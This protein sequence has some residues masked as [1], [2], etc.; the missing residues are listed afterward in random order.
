MSLCWA[1]SLPAVT[2]S[3]Q[4]W[5]KPFSAYLFSILSLYSHCAHI[6]TLHAAYLVNLLPPGQS[7]YNSSCQQYNGVYYLMGRFTLEGA[8]NNY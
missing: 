4:P 3:S 2:V 5:E 7:R 8:M 6:F 1:D